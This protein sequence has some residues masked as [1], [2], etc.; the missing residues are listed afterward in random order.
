MDR[1]VNNLEHNYKTQLN[2]KY[3]YEKPYFPKETVITWYPPGLVSLMMHPHFLCTVCLSWSYLFR[4]FAATYKVILLC[5]RG[6]NK[7]I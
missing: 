7:Q 5:S 1:S 3:T 4:L 2:D 6:I